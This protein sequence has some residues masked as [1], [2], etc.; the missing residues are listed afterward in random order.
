MRMPPGLDGLETI[1]HLWTVDPDIQ[2]VVCSAYT[3]YDWLELLERL[4]HSDQLIVIKKP[5]EPIEVFCSLRSALSRKWQNARALQQPTW[6]ASERV[7]TDRLPKAAEA[8]N[9]Q[10]RH[11]ASHDA[12]TGLPNRLLL[13]DRVRQAIAQADRHSHEF[14]L[15]VIDLDRFK[16]INDSLGH[17]AG[18]DLLR[19][20][21]RG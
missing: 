2:V 7:V 5:F 20:V 3:D 9:G 8:A 1:E 18:D 15:M 13:D 21:A 10:L 16:V 14:A 4:G 6:K 11:L 17:R 12:L 19:E